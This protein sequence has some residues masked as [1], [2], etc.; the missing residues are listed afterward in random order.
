MFIDLLAVLLFTRKED[1]MER[2]IPVQFWL[3]RFLSAKL[4]YSVRLKKIQKDG[5]AGK[6]KNGLIFLLAIPWQ[7]I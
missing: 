7:T 1:N 4:L 6:E 2:Y 5:Q 3:G